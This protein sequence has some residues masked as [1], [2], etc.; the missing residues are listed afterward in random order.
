MDDVAPGQAADF[1]SSCVVTR[2]KLAEDRRKDQDQEGRH[3]NCCLPVKGWMQ[4]I[5]TRTYMP[6]SVS[7]LYPGVA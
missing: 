7:G 4:G 6:S 1:D 2:L 3:W 5:G